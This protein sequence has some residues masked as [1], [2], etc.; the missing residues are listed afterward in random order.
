M[1]HMCMFVT[2]KQIWRK[3][4][5]IKENLKTQFSFSDRPLCIQENRI[6]RSDLGSNISI[7]THFYSKSIYY[8][9]YFRKGDVELKLYN[10]LSVSSTNISVD[11]F[12]VTV[13]VSGYEII[14]NITEFSDEDIGNYTI[15]MHNEFSYAMC[16]VQLKPHGGY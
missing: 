1:S 16:T 14:I 12:N 4:Y 2:W 10:N 13:I 9:I 5:R 8:N 11:I 6:Q 7:V 15:E 3:D